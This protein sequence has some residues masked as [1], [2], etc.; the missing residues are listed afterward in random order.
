MGKMDTI[1][2]YTS[3]SRKEMEVLSRL[4]YEDIRIISRNYLVKIVKNI[5]RANKLIYNLRRKGRLRYIGMKKYLVVPIRAP[6]QQWKENEYLIADALMEGKDYYIGYNNMFNFYGFTPQI[7][8]TIFILNLKYSKKKIIDEIS[9]KFIKISPSKYYGITTI[10]IGNSEVKISD[11]ERTIIDLVYN[12]KPLG[13]LK[14]VY[15]T[16]RGVLPKVD[17]SKLIKYASKFS[18]P[19]TRKRIGYI[20]ELYKVNS[21]KLKPLK[22]SIAKNTALTT[23]FEVKNRSGK[24]SKDWNLIING[25]L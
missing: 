24:I 5:R 11:K 4:E 23:L 2:R 7:S 13:S 6:Y 10:R 9:Y 15:N 8:Q 21:S 1:R 19:S 25:Q 14:N 16:V 18:N 22:K 3:L 17:I 20:L 12:Y